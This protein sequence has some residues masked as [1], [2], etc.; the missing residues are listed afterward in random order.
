MELDKEEFIVISGASLVIHDIIEETNDIDLTCSKN[1][2][3]Y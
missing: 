3:M 2:M 1:I